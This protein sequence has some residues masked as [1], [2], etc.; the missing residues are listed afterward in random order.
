MDIHELTPNI[1][2]YIEIHRRYTEIHKNTWKYIEIQ[3]N[4]WK[5]T[6]I[7]KSTYNIKQYIT[8]RRNLTEIL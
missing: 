8:I 5:Y 3:G 7:H 2:K 4:T 1:Q 6:E